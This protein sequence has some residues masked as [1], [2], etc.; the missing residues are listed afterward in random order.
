VNE[1][2]VLREARTRLAVEGWA[3]GA[4]YKPGVGYCLRGA[5]NM[6]FGSEYGSGAKADIHKLV[7]DQLGTSLLGVVTWNNAPGRTKA[8]VLALLDDVIAKLAEHESGDAVPAV[9]V[10]APDL[11][12]V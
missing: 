3:Q 5:V 6:C 9:E 7:A 2:E 10:A 4:L 12:A 1:L 11:V 8:E